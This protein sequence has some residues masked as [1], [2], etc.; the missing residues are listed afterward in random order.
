MH[1]DAE[2]YIEAIKFHTGLETQVELANYFG[3]AQSAIAGWIKRN[4]VRTIKKY[5]EL[6]KLDLNEI[7]ESVKKYKDID[8][9]LQ[10]TTLEN[11]QKERFK[12][13]EKEIPNTQHNFSIN[14]QVGFYTVIDELRITIFD[15][16]EGFIDRDNDEEVKKLFEDFNALCNYVVTPAA[17]KMIKTIEDFR[18]KREQEMKENNARARAKQLR[19]V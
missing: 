12:N 19:G 2:H 9:D 10:L 5:I 3:V 11:A 17:A 13:L 18:A 15:A 6:K 7:E 1:N 16:V 14:F 8:L 4:S